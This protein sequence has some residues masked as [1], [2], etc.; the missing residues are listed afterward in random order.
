MSNPLLADAVRRWPESSDVA[1]AAKLVADADVEQVRRWAVL[2]LVDELWKIERTKQLVVERD[3]SEPT[4]A[5][6]SDYGPG[7]RSQW[8]NRYGTSIASKG[9]GASKFANLF[10]RVRDDV[11]VA[12]NIEGST[13]GEVVSDDVVWLTSKQR[14]AFRRWMGSDLSRWLDESSARFINESGR[15]IFLGEMMEPEEYRSLLRA[16]R[17]Q[18]TNKLIA[19]VRETTR[20]EVTADLLA[21]LFAVGDGRRVTWAEAT[22]DDHRQRIEMLSANIT[23]NAEA[24]ARHQ[25]AI[26][27]ITDAGVE[28]LGDAK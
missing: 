18:Q 5:P 2:H 22:K 26:Q 21:S 9:A 15:M 10:E 7:V 3:A 14:S 19:D 11:T 24:A 20:L 1:I 12:F 16:L 25:I 23:A 8:R 17:N 4:P 27:I 13:Y 6:V 28:T